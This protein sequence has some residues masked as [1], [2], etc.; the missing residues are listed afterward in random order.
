MHTEIGVAMSKYENIMHGMKVVAKNVLPSTSHAYLY[1]S[2]ARG[3]AREDSDW[4]VLLVL[5]KDEIE[6]SDYDEVSY[7]FTYFGWENGEC[8]IPV[9]F[10]KKEW[11]ENSYTSFNSNVEQDRILIA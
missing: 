1:G 9:L 4:D 8:I 2:R 3:E 10:T 7:P 5:D 6:D 11:D